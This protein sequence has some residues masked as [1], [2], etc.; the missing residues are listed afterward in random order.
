MGSRTEAAKPS[1]RPQLL[2]GLALALLTLLA[3]APVLQNGFVN[4]DDDLYVTAN[5]RVQSGLTLDNL[6]WAFTTTDYFPSWNPLTWMSLQLDHQL[7]GLNPI[8]YHLTNVLLHL[9]STVVLF[10]TLSA[11]TNK[12][13]LS[14][15]VAAFFAIHPLNVEPVAWVSARKDVLSTLFW[16]LTLAAY[17]HY[18]RAPGLVRYLVALLLFALGLLAKPMLVTLPFVLLLLDWWPLGRAVLI[19]PSPCAVTLPRLLAEKVPFLLLAL[20]SCAMTLYA[21]RGSLEPMHRLT[22]GTR[23]GVAVVSCVNYLTR[24]F[25]PQDLIAFY[26]HP[27]DSLP[28][29]RILGSLLALAVLTLGLTLAGRKRPYLLVGWLWFL[30]TLVP[31]IGLLPVGWHATA[32]RYTYV[33]MIGLAILLTW[34]GADLVRA[35]PAL[36]LPVRLGVLALL[37]MALAVT[38]AQIGVWH[39]SLALWKNA[40]RVAPDSE[41]VQVNL[42][43]ALAEKGQVKEA[44]KHFSEALR[45]E[46]ESARAHQNMGQA[47]MKLGRPREAIGHFTEALRIAPGSALT[48]NNL[49]RAWMVLGT[50]KEAEASFRAALAADPES[51]SFHA[52]LGAALM[53]QGKPREALL[54]YQAA[55]ERKPGGAS[56]HSSLGL[57]L[58]DVGREEESRMQ[59]QEADRLDPQWRQKYAK[60]AWLLATR[61]DPRQRDGP[62]ALLLARQVCLGVRDPGPEDWEVLAAAYAEVGRFDEAVASQ[63]KG[64]ALLQASA[65]SSRLGPMENRLQLYERRQPFRQ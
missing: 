41:V 58:H 9:A 52:N 45:Y 38:W 40:A 61:R 42:G 24:F 3:Y 63:R 31:V 30:G 53:A 32:D 50:H 29:G 51:A 60:T 65:R 22:L 59:F 54:A 28:L 17:W 8:G 35:R 44:L 5:P 4:Y 16:M 25:Y 1:W 18:T 20:V 13:G 62:H 57:A 34:G 36:L 43:V 10:L 46:S 64:L 56:Y 33:P 15:V 21:Q 27:R 48:L 14:A 12:L 39:D 11:M 55:V 49:G 23:A 47:L 37:G 6:L 26:A 7:H 19:G 2:V